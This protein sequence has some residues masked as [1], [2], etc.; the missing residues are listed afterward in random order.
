MSIAPRPSV[1]FL[2]NRSKRVRSGHP[3]VYSNEV[4]MDEDAR[5]I[6]PGS[7]V[8]LIDAGG[9]ALGAATFNPHS[10]IAGRMLSSDPDAPV[11]RDFFISRLELAV[12]LRTRLFDEPFYRLVHA[13]G[14]ALPGFVIDRFGDVIVCQTNTAGADRHWTDMLAAIEAVIGPRAVVLRSDSPVRRLEGLDVGAAIATGTIDGAVEVREDGV[15]GLADVMEGQK[16]GWYF[17]QRASRRF[18]A[19]LARGARVL[20]VYSYSGAF[21]LHAAAAGAADVLA[22]DR[23]EAALALG[24]RAAELGGVAERW[25]FRRAEAFAELARL[26][27]ENE[28]FD[29]VI[30]DPPSFVKSRKDLRSGLRGYRKLTRLAAARV[31]PGGCLFIASCSHN[32]SAADFADAVRRGIIDAGRGGRILRAAGASADHPQHPALPEG[33]Y[34]K[35][36]ALQI[37]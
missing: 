2:P 27:E 11:D 12:D 26:A 19:S 1:H 31:T 22:I 23:S 32:V 16:T 17:D 37:D 20:D 33:A 8:R 13:E 5:G 9:E 18:M 21:A 29:V 30:A 15:A 36:L 4:R 28:R 7:I 25:Q 24:A 10:L 35:S 3:W 14:D 6:A 34:L